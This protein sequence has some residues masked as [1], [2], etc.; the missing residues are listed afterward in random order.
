MAATSIRRSKRS[1]ASSPRDSE[2]P[3][4]PSVET[5]AGSSRSY[6]PRP[7]APRPRIRKSTYLVRKEESE[8][9]SKEV[10]VLKS[11]MATL[12]EREQGCVTEK[13]LLNAVLQEMWRGQ[14]LSFAVTQSA[15][16]GLLNASQANPLTT[17]IRLGEDPTERRRTL[18]NLKEPKLRNAFEYSRARSQF[19]DPFKPH[20]SEERFEDAS[21]GFCCAR[22]DLIQFEGVKSVKQVY[23]ALVYYLL[24]IEITMSERL[25][26]ITVREDSDALEDSS[27][28]NFRL[29]S[30]ESGVQVE[31]NTVSVISFAESHAPSNGSPCGIVTVDFVDDDALYPYK[32]QERARRD[33]SAAMVLTPH[34]RKSPNSD[35][36]ELVVVMAQSKFH[37]FSHAELDLAPH[38]ALELRDMGWGRVTV[39]T[40]NELLYSKVALPAM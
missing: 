36:E 1:A 38:V 39:K 12:R 23:D 11:Q 7:T 27:V 3:A 40:L 16:S 22:F 32:P 24:N 26:N 13:Q 14:Q 17:Y 30:T 35:E 8:Q 25:G 37:R 5:S 9:L 15:V 33:V 18:M 20:H 29:L 4:S 6:R 31:S 28:A 21:G 10:E 2:S 34:M 19:L